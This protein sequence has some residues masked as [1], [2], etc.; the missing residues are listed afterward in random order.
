MESG[1]M[2]EVHSRVHRCLVSRCVYVCVRVR[3]R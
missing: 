2:D 1:L 3:V